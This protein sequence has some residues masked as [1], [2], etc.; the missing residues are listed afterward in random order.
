LP[1]TDIYKFI[2]NIAINEKLDLS[3]TIIEKIQQIYNSDIRSIINFIQLH[4]NIKLWDTNIITD[5]IWEKIYELLKDKAN[6]NTIIEYVNKISTQYNMDKK[7]ILK[8]Y[9]NY[10]I[11]KRK[12]IVTPSFLTAVEVIMHSNDSNIEYL[13]NYFISSGQESIEKKN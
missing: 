13:I 9:F 10:I 1:K 8:N 4:Q 7:N 3:D 12:D 6:R 11:R 2:N 5:E